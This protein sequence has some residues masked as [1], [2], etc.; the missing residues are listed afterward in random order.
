M[1]IPGC[2]SCGYPIAGEVGE[3]IP[4]PS[5]HSI[6]QVIS[7]G[8]TIPTPVIVGALFFVFGMFLGPSIIASSSGG[9]AWLEK[10]ARGG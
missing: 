2:A 10:R 4:C 5:C 7:E 6:N 8:V 3:E 9:K 1:P